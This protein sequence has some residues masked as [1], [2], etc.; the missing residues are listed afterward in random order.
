MRS[1]DP[2]HP[3]DPLE[4]QGPYDRKARGYLGT[5]DRESCTAREPAGP[6]FG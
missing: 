1:L 4:L 6:W 2:W 3:H 5:L